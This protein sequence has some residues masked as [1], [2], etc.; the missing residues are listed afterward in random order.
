[1]NIMK[2]NTCCF[3]RRLF[4]V[5]A[6]VALAPSVFCAGDTLSRAVPETVGMSSE[7]LERILPA[8]KRYVDEG[9]LS[10]VITL[11]SRQGKVVHFESCGLRDEEAE[12]A[13]ERDTLVRIYSMTKPI[14]A[15]GLM[16][17]HE[18]GAF[19]LNDP[20]AKFIPE[21]RGLKVL[22][23]GEE[24]EPKRKM[25]VHHLLTHT[26]GLTYGFFGNTPVDQQYREAGVLGE[27]N[28]EEMIAHLAA[29]PLQYHPGERWHYSVAVDVQGALIERLSG[30][31]LDRYFRERIFEPLGME[32]TFFQVPEEKVERFAANYRYNNR[33]QQ[34]TLSDA[35]QKSK[36]VHPV[37]FFS[38]GGGLVST[39]A[40]YWKFCQM[41]LNGGTYNGVRLL[42]R[43]TVE[44]M[45][46][47]HLP[48]VVEEPKRNFGFG[49]GFRVLLNVPSTGV[50]GSVG[51]YSWGGAAGTIFWIDPQEDLIAV[52]MIQLMNSPYGL[53]R[54]MKSLIYQSLID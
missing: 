21:F 15:V 20:V 44:L 48:A 49:L 5:A 50:P 38:A 41:L 47:N 4:S 25:T 17:L 37:T 19:Q 22:E 54:E 53:K 1:M 9:K 32:D 52:V 13:M 39:A 33:K 3:C 27:K 43:K 2:A 42:G 35:P 30:M 26:A 40:D 51:K 16:M 28:L 14:A 45:T 46:S 24:V 10:G 31:P 29:I 6:I 12:K 18:E 8:V 7:R 36:F 11:V 23:D 34:R